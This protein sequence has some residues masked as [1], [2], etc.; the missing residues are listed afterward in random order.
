MRFLRSIIKQLAPTHWALLAVMALGVGLRSWGLMWGAPERVDLHPDETDYVM[1]NAIGILNRLE[2]VWAHAAVFDRKTLDPVFLNYP[3]FLM[4]L[5]AFT[6]AILRRIHLATQVWQLF[7]VGRIFNVIFGT[8]TIPAVAWLAAELGAKKRGIILAAFWMAI[9]P[10]H[11]WEG[12][13]A[14]TDIAMTFFT[15]LTL[16]FAVR[17]I[18]HQQWRDYAFAGV[19]LGLATGSKYTAAIAAI[20]IFLG[21]VMARYPFRRKLPKLIFC[22]ALSAAACFAVTPYSFLRFR[23]LLAAMQYEHQ[24]TLSHH[25]GFAV[26]A[27]GWWYHRWVYQ[28]LAAWPFSLGFCLYA[29]CIGG[30]VWALFRMN[31]GTAVV[32]GFTAVFFYVTGSWV[33]TPLRYYLPILVVG[34]TLAGKWMGDWLIM[35]APIYRRI[36]ATSLTAVGLYTLFFVIQTTHRYSRDTRMAAGRWLNENLPAQAEIV[37][38]GWS[39]YLPLPDTNRFRVQFPPERAVG[40][41]K[42]HDD[43]IYLVITSLQYQRHY[44]HGNAVFT[45][46]YDRVRDPNGPFYLVRRFQSHFLNKRVY[47]KLDPMFEGYFVSP[48]IE[49]YRFKRYAHS[50]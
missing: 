21:V 44:R 29:A 9:M 47:L 36:A 8:L 40:K 35:P 4:Y 32:L 50:A 38:L 24:H 31:R 37:E 48:T 20:A 28:L 3:A 23:D 46:A 12:H 7:L 22:G 30:A 26:Y 49:V 33:F 11:V 42:Y 43:D 13:A 1:A 10:L 27:V 6:G 17:L 41:I 14:I 19:A 45:E 16:V 18:R 34:V 25:Y 2:A 39:R 5:I 15:T